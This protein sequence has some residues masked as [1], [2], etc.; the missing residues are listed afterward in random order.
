MEASPHPEAAGWV[1]RSATI[2]R[3]EI[4]GGSTEPFATAALV[5]HHDRRMVAD[6][7][8]EVG[9]I[10]IVHA[11]AAVGHEAADR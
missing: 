7:A 2:L 11:N 10:L 1:E 4:S 6:A 8:V 3:A 9:D 5:G